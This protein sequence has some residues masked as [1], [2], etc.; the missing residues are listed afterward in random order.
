MKEIFIADKQQ[1]INDEYPFESPPQLTDKRKCLHCGEVITV[2]DYKV[3][4]NEEMGEDYI[5]CPN[6][7]DCDGSIIDW[8]DPI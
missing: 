6:A 7:P 5:C 8:V 3:F 4:R 1:F 2:G